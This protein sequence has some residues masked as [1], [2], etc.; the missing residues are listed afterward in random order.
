MGPS[1]VGYISTIAI[2]GGTEREVCQIGCA[3][4]AR[5]LIRI[6]PIDAVD[7]A[8]CQTD[9]CNCCLC[10]LMNETPSAKS[11]GKRKDKPTILMR[12]YELDQH[13]SVLELLLNCSG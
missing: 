13:L 12:I 1:L 8:I 10:K 2:V 6:F 3:G 9:R 11:A 5:P 4:D 7:D